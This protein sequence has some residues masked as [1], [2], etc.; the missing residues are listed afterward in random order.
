MW[1]SPHLYLPIPEPSWTQRVAAYLVMGWNLQGAQ[2][3]VE[4]SSLERTGVHLAFGC[5]LNLI[6]C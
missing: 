4:V 3:F 5:W 6:T 1:L 2:I